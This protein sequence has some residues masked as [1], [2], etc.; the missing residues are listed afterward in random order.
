MQA[1]IWPNEVDA[2]GAF[3][4]A[5]ILLL[6]TITDRTGAA[7]VESKFGAVLK[8]GVVAAEDSF[9][10]LVGRKHDFTPLGCLQ[11]E[12]NVAAMGWIDQLVI[13]E[14]FHARADVDWVIGRLLSGR[15]E[16]MCREQQERNR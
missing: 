8:D 11:F 2:I 13:D 7:V 1:K 4:V 15:G 6:R 14:H 9:P 3:G 5:S 16:R 10:R 12:R